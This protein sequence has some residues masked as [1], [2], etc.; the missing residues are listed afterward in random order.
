MAPSIM[1]LLD[2]SLIA[3][4]AAT[5][6]GGSR[7]MSRVRSPCLSRASPALGRSSQLGHFIVPVCADVIGLSPSTV[8]QFRTVSSNQS[9]SDMPKEVSPALSPTNQACLKWPTAALCFSTR[10][11]SFQHPCK[12]AYCVHWKMARFAGLERPARDT[13]TRG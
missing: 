4:L 1:K 12:C 2:S 3:Q 5:S 9:C 13:L 10:L 8:A 7:V 11:L 6:L